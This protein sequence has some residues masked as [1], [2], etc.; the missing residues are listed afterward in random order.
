[1]NLPDEAEPHFR[2][3]IE[4]AVDSITSFSQDWTSNKEDFLYIMNNL[5][6]SI[7]LSILAS[8]I[9]SIPLRNVSDRQE[10]IDSI[11]E[12]LI[13][14]IMGL[15]EDLKE[16]RKTGKKIEIKKVH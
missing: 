16:L 14:N 9:A 15:P 7:H 8:V 12:S 3:T 10:F 4:N 1:M 2:K 11:C 6:L 13:V 5:A